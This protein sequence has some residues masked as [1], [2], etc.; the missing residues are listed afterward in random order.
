MAE[1]NKSI[2]TQLYHKNDDNQDPTLENNENDEI[3]EDV[4]LGGLTS[5]LLSS[6]RED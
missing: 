4:K 6:E 3:N 2:P 1:S 5:T